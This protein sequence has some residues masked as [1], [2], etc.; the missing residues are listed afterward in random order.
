MPIVA[1]DNDNAFFVVAEN[2]VSVQRV[3][4]IFERWIRSGRQFANA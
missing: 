4:E 3:L 2:P 1:T